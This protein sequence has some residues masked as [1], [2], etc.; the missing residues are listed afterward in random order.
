MLTLT[1]LEAFTMKS[2]WSTHA[3]LTAV[4]LL[5]LGA[6]VLFGI[7]LIVDPRI[8]AGAPAWLKPAKFAASLA[9]YG[10]T[11]VWLFRYL[12]DYPRTRRIAGTITAAVALIEVGLI[13]LQAWRG[14]PRRFNV[15]TPFD[16]TV[17]ATMGAA[18]AVQWVASLALVVA[19]LRQRFEDRALA[20]ALRTGM[21]LAVSGAAI[22]GLMTRPTP[23][24]LAD[25]RA[26][27]RM[28]VSGAHSI[29]GPDGGPGL[30]LT[31]WG[32]EDGDL[33]VPPFLRPP[34]LQVPPP[35]PFRP[36]P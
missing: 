3:A 10:L 23:A 21:I 25:A 15:A 26:A 19:L 29:G 4:S 12:P 28:A 14:T 20:S 1:T 32:T 16:V 27:H 31:E 13:A 6:L 22:G 9:V 36:A 35:P 24:Q 8:V 33:P 7:G 17:F 5:L 2:L 30:P 18:I 34:A 11:L